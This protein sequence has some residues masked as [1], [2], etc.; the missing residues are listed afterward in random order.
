MNSLFLLLE[1]MSAVL[2]PQERRRLELRQMGNDELFK[3]YDN[4]IILRLHN[5]KNLRDTRKKLAEFKEYPGGRPPSPEL[6]RAFLT[7]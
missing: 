3:L 7:R 6:A 2:G 1:I 4:E 5:P